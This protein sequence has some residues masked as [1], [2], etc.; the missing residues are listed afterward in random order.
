[1]RWP[2]PFGIFRD[3]RQLLVSDNSLLLAW[4]NGLDTFDIAKKFFLHESTVDSRLWRIRE[5]ER[6]A[7]DR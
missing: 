6:I 4:R 2:S 7:A 1:M 5:R 3:D